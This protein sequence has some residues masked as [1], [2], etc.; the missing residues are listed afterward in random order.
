MII[1]LDGALTVW[2]GH[3][4]VWRTDRLRYRSRILLLFDIFIVKKT[5]VATLTTCMRVCTLCVTHLVPT[6]V[7]EQEV[8]VGEEVRGRWMFPVRVT[9]PDRYFILHKLPQLA[10]I[11]QYVFIITPSLSPALSLSLSHC[12]SRVWRDER[13]GFR[14]L[15]QMWKRHYTVNPYGAMLMWGKSVNLGFKGAEMG[16]NETF[17]ITCENNWTQK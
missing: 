8:G 4:C 11:S 1:R 2:P 10:L 6:C 9:A 5:Q 3:V 12:I 14:G 7:C 15:F 13:G 17:N 16:M